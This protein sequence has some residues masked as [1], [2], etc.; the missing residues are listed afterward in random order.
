[1]TAYHRVYDLC[2]LQADCEE[3][4]INSMPSQVDLRTCIKPTLAPTQPAGP[5]HYILCVYRTTFFKE[6]QTQM[7]GHVVRLHDNRCVIRVD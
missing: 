4:G 5:Y 6:D 3:I 7:G 1:M 2:H